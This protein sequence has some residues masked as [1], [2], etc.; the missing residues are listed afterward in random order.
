M[1][2]ILRALGDA[3]RREIVRALR[4]GELTAGEIASRFPI[5]DA[6]ISHHLMVLK[7]AGLISGRREGRSIIYSVNRVV[8]DAFMMDLAEFL[9][10]D[11]P[12]TGQL[13]EG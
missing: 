2:R 11:V 8:I 3:T 1:D 5:T 4:D 12:F 7:A 13:G 6:S 10:G 9:G